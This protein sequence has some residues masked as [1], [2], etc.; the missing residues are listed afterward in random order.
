MGSIFSPPKPKPF[1]PTEAQKSLERSQ[2]ETA[3]GQKSEIAERAAK[4]GSRRAGRRS[5]LTGGAMGAEDKKET[6][7]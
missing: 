7:G 2:L 5:L 1:E 4:A 6:L 3:A